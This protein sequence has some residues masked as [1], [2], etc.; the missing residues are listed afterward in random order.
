MPMQPPRFRPAGWKPA[1]PRTWVATTRKKSRHERG[2]GRAHTAMR[3]RVLE[4]EPLC[5]TG[6]GRLT[7]IADHRVPKAEGG[8]DERDN[9][10][11]MCEPC[12]KIKTAA[13]SARAK[14]RGQRT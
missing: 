3:K 13:E 9:Y 11:G 4:E 5:I 6:C 10:Q 7:T 14:K 1:P 8:T 2:Y 12:H